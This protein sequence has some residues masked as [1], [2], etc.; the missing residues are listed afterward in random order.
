MRCF[1]A[2]DLPEDIKQ[3]LAKIQAELP[4][5]NTKLLNVSPEILHLTLRFL[6]EINDDQVNKIKDIFKSVKLTKFRARLNSAGVFPSE[7]FIRVVWVNLEP[8]DKFKEI[9][10]LIESELEKA[11]F[12]KDERFESHVTLARVRWIKD[13]KDFIDKLKKI[14]IKPLEFDVSNIKLKKS[15]L[16]LKG[17]IYEDVLRIEM[18]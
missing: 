6:G 15:T 8:S 13:R 11:G 4:Q 17:P 10:D 5:E 18:V 1:I 7:D 9:R 14:S 2:I 12:K 3:E 16:T